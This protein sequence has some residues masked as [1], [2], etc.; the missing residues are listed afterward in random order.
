VNDYLTQC[1]E[2]YRKAVVKGSFVK[3]YETYHHLKD[4]YRMTRIGMLNEEN[5]IDNEF[6]KLSEGWG[7]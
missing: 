7:T 6:R 4:A 3:I 1:T 5:S 2:E